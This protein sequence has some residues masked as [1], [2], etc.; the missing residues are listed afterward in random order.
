MSFDQ[1]QHTSNSLAV[2]TSQGVASSHGSFGDLH[3]SDRCQMQE[4]LGMVTVVVDIILA[5]NQS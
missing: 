3:L 5:I 2:A 1:Q 4:Q